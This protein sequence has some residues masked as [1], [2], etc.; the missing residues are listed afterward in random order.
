MYKLLHGQLPY[1]FGQLTYASL[2]ILNKT[3][4]IFFYGAGGA[5]AEV[6]EPLDMANLKPMGVMVSQHKGNTA[7]LGEYKSRL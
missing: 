6:F 1:K 2:N 3:T 5:A 4:N 7:I